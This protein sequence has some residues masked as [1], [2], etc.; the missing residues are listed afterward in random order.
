[1]KSI[2]ILSFIVL[3]LSACKKPENRPCWKTAG[4]EIEMTIALEPFTKLFL[5]EHV[6]FV[7]VQDTVEKV[8]LMGGKNL[9]NF[10]SV[11]V[12]DQ[13]LE[14]GNENKCTFLRSYDK[15][16]KAEIHF[17]SIDNIRFEGSESLTNKGKLNFS[18]LTL[19]IRDGA[20]PVNL[21][22]DALAII[23]TIS[24]GWGD[25]TFSGNV[26][27]ANFNVWSNGFCNTYGL[28]V[29]DSITVVSSTQGPVHIN[30]DQVK[31]KAE[32]NGSGNIYYRGTPNSISFNQY[33]LGELIDNN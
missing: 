16:V 25:F 20:G 1:M 5:K 10:I 24:H 18:W 13:T 17:K 9:L 3:F 12:S 28:N 23:A 27:Y 19:L 2:A 14:I 31:L 26:N 32:T 21:N 6:E 33:G 4:E 15:K 7:L 22:V 11:S 29:K 30:A 8:V